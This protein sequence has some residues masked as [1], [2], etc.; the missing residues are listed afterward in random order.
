MRNSATVWIEGGFLKKEGEKAYPTFCVFTQEQYTQLEQT[1]FAPLAQKLTEEIKSLA[2]DLAD[3]CKKKIPKHL[4]SYFD[5][6][7]TRALSDLGYLTSVLAFQDGKLYVPA[8]PEEGKLLT[9]LYVT[10]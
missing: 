6:Y 1:V 9:L 4:S 10:E 2:L 5:W 3:L 7:L 8:D